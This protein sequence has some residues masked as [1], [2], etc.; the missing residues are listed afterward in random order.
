MFLCTQQKNEEMKNH[1]H[2]PIFILINIRESRLLYS[3]VTYKW[4]EY[5]LLILLIEVRCDFMIS[6]VNNKKIY[7]CPTL[8]SEDGSKYY[9]VDDAKHV[10]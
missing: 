5:K 7:D 1:R 8:C 6:V 9:E 2:D 3:I 4:I 10:R